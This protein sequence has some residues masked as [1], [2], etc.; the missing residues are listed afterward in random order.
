MLFWSTR[1]RPSQEDQNRRTSISRSIS[2]RPWGG[3]HL[4][5]LEGPT[6][7]PRYPSQRR[8][9]DR[10]WVFEGPTTTEVTRNPRLIWQIVSLFFLESRNNNYKRLRVVQTTKLTEGGKILGAH[11]KWPSYL[12]WYERLLA[13]VFKNTTSNVSLR[14]LSRV[15][16]QRNP[17]LLRWW[18]V[19][20]LDKSPMGTNHFPCR[21][22]IHSSLGNDIYFSTYETNMYTCFLSQILRCI[23]SHEPLC[24]EE[25]PRRTNFQNASCS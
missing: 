19:V 16:P 25:Q 21:L 18:L 8:N 5:N 3:S 20:S 7:N 22:M 2:R 23:L 4:E 14:F 12:T 6:Q 13:W 24:K 15:T 17:T 11:R 9:I 10:H 1:S